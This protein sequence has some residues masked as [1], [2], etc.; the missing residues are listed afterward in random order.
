M[1]S[2][3]FQ[4]RP[5]TP[6]EKVD[7]SRQS[8]CVTRRVTSTL[9]TLSEAR[10]IYDRCLDLIPPDELQIFY[11]RRP[12]NRHVLSVVCHGLVREKLSKILQC[13]PLSLVREITASG[14]PSFRQ[15]SDA[16]WDFSLSYSRTHVLIGI[17]HGGR[18]GVD[19][20]E[21]DAELP[22]PELLELTLTPS[23]IERYLETS[24]PDRARLFTS[25]WVQKE[26][27]YKSRGAGNGF[28]PSVIPAKLK[29]CDLLDQTDDDFQL[30]FLE[31][32]LLACCISCG[33][34]FC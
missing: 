2:T 20:Q 26:A 30:W 12:W 25:W 33:N 4:S 17:A 22:T 34:T 16:G 13:D 9:I 29:R 8:R 15:A 14:R 10:T 5:Y 31:N 3:V 7:R 21:I 23:E 11:A 6:S 1:N 27:I 32:G 28:E 19:I 18:V 24:L